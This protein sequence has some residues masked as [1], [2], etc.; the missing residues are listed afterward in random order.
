[1]GW[2]IDEDAYTKR[3]VAFVIEIW[4]HRNLLRRLI[5]RIV[6]QVESTVIHRREKLF[7]KGRVCEALQPLVLFL[8]RPALSYRLRMGGG[9][10]QKEILCEIPVQESVLHLIR[11]TQ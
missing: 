7:F 2:A 3:I 1:M 6:G 9:H 11:V 4:L 10:L 5:L 8:S